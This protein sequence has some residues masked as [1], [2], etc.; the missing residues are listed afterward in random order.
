MFTITPAEINDMVS[1]NV[2]P[3]K[4]YLGGAKLMAFSEPGVA[5]LSTV[6]KSKQA[7]Q[8]N[9]GYYACFCTNGAFD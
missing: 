2:I 4:S 9:I 1:Q 8:A 6:L 5:M 7:L 3:S